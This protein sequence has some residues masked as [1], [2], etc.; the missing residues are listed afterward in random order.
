MMYNAEQNI[1]RVTGHVVSVQSYKDYI[2]K[3]YRY[4]I[5]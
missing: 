5:T 1:E 2:T 3:K 4:L